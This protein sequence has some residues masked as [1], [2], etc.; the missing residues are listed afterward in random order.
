MYKFLSCILSIL[1]I[2]LSC[3]NPSENN[4]REKGELAQKNKE[5]ELRI[6]E[7]QLQKKED[8]LNSLT[9]NKTKSLAD[10]FEKVKK[11]VFL[12]YTTDDINTSQGSAF[13]INSNGD[14]ISNYHVFE[15]A[16]KAIA[17]NSEGKK[18]VIDKIYT[19][20]KQKD[21][22][23]FRIRSTFKD[24]NPVK[25]ASEIPRVG[26]ECFTVGNP[27]GLFQTLSTGVISGYRDN[28]HLL[29]ISVPITHGSSGGPLF[30]KNGEVFGITTS[31]L[32][33]ADL[34]FAININDLPLMDYAN[35]TPISIDLDKSVSTGSNQSS[36][37]DSY[38][39]LVYVSSCFIIVTGAFL[40]EQ[41]ARNY[42]QQ[43]I[44]KGYL[45]S[46]YLWIPDFPSLSGKKFYATFIGPFTSY[47]EC[48]NNLE[49][50][51]RTG[52]FWYG[53]KVS[54]NNENVEIRL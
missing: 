23:L 42:V 54:L 21:Y 27:R 46:G 18:F 49:I 14:A 34:N 17:I 4:S 53:K 2:A 6:K 48:R 20:D 52:R 25:I 19:Y 22:I 15:N 9:S 44:N 40:Y 45:N 30:N 39:K 26:D 11:S 28:G 3:N 24:F 16:S 29:Q 37:L 5:L 43:E 47:D 1:L 8:S 35:S 41:D 33:E 31:G 13:I 51:D 50:L 32:G 36:Y 10:E 12:I 7:I 38:G